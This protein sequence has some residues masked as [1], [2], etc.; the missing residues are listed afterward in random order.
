MDI[1]YQFVP[2]GFVATPALGKVYVDVGNAFCAGIL[3][4]H[5]PDAPDACTAMLVLNHPEYVIRQV[6]DDGLTIIPHQYPDLD[7]VTGAYFARMHVQGNEIKP[8]HH[9]WA[10]YVCRVDQ[11]FTTLTPDQAI[12]P[13]SVFMMRMH[14]LKSKLPNNAETAS[15]VMLDAGFEFL[16]ALFDGLKRGESLKDFEQLSVSHQFEDE[17]TAI[18]QDLA[19]YKQDMKRVETFTCQLPKSDGK[20]MKEVAG[21]WIEKPASSMFKSWAR[22]DA[23]HAGNDKG[24][25][26]LGIQVSDKRFILSVDPSSGV[27]LKGLGELIEQAETKK[28]TPLGLDRKG[29][30]RPGYDSPDPW[31]DGRSPLHHYTIIDSPKAGTV[32]QMTDIQTIVSHYIKNA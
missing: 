17:I 13:Y 23:E 15:Q 11:G 19:L 25:V 4:H 6:S 20:G 1:S 7:A 2:M 9:D 21:L 26:F 5:H 22:G 29:E 3:D 27:Y 10:E 14:L 16:D 28:R 31:Y 8:M 32:L 30:N 12:T 18:K 24:F